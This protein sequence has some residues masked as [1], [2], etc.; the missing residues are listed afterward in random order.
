MFTQEFPWPG[1]RKLKGEMAER[2]AEAEFQ[3][4]QTVQLGVLA[5]LKQ[6][7]TASPTPMR[8]RMYSRATATCS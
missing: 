4:Y 7:G 1:K 5:R 6:P 2:E 3:Q 8:R